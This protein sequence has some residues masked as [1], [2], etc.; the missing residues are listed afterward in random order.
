MTLVWLSKA[1]VPLVAPLTSVIARGSPFGSL[2]LASSIDDAMVRAVSCEVLNPLSS[3][4]TGAWL[5][6]SLTVRLTAV[7][8]VPPAPSSM[9]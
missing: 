1:T 4:E 5:T 7:V 3:T 2:S 8:A 9:V 6:D